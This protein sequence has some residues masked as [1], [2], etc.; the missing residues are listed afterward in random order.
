MQIEFYLVRKNLNC[1][2]GILEWF[3]IEYI[4]KLNLKKEFDF[5]DY[6]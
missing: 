1:Y 6:K 4:V 2:V 5:I 3:L